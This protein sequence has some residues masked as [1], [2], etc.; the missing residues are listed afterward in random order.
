MIPPFLEANDIYL[1]PLLPE[2]ADGPYLNWFNDDVV[3]QGN[4]H[5]VVP[6]T[7]QAAQAYIDKAQTFDSQL[8]LAVVLQEGHKHIGNVALLRI[9]FISRSSEFAIVIGEKDCWGKGYSKQAARLIFDH[10]FFTINLKRIYCGTFET[11]ITMK[12]LAEFMGMREEGR[13][14]NAAFKNNGY[15]DIIEFGVLRDEYIFQPPKPA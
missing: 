1:R 12:K 8:V 14:R 5:H 15:V 9:D 3:C 4:S 7:Y 11:N 13:R 10:A 6:Y 2:D